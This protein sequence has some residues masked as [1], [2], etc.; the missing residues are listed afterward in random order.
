MS[1]GAKNTPN[2]SR[3]INYRFEGP[4]RESK[5]EKLLERAKADGIIFEFDTGRGN[6]VWFDGWPGPEIRA[7][8]AKVKQIIKEG[9]PR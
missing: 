3:G 4:F 7:L 1:R 8:V 2:K 6:L 5:M 9:D